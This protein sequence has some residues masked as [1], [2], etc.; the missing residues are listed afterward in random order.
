MKET[1]ISIIIP[2]FNRLRTMGAILRAL[3]S[4]TLPLGEFEVIAVDD[5]STDGTLEMLKNYQGPLSLLVDTTGLPPGVYGYHQA[6]NK[7][8]TLSHGKYLVFMDS[9]IMPRHDA[10]E[11]FLAAHARWEARGEKVLIRAWWTRRRHPLKMWLKG[12][13]L[14]R[15]SPERALKKDKKFQKLYKKREN[16]RPKDAPSAFLSIRKDLAVAVDGFPAHAQCYGM[17][18]EFQKRLVEL[19]G[20]KIVFEPEVYAIHGP[21]PG[22][23]EAEAYRWTRRLKDKY[24]KEGWKGLSSSKDPRKH[25]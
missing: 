16:L 6:I 13:S 12:T 24:L 7:G 5:G 2:T 21:L 14:N 4:Q 25:P 19:E 9:D 3:E 11:K 20:V 22:D 10:L 15:Y 1:P 23:I 18:Y 8:I 17:D